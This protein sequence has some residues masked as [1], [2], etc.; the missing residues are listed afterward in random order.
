MSARFLQARL[1]ESMLPG[2]G[3]QSM[4]AMAVA[5]HGSLTSETFAKMGRQA[6]SLMQRYL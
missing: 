1:P 3:E 5:Q 4:S 6:R 2:L